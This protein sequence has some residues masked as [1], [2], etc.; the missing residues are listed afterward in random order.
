[1][2]LVHHDDSVGELERLFLIVRD[3]DAGDFDLVVEP[4]QPSAQFLTHLGVERSERLVQ[5]QDFWLDGGAF[6]RVRPR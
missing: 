2:P 4:P 6:A 5:Q 3:E 1:M